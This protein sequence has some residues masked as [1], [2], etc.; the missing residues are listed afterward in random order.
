MNEQTT[1]GVG[2]GR[3]TFADLLNFY[4]RTSETPIL[5]GRS[6]AEL[7]HLEHPPGRDAVVATGRGWVCGFCDFKWE[8]DQRFSERLHAAEALRQMRNFHGYRDDDYSRKTEITSETMLAIAKLSAD[9]REEDQPEKSMEQA[10]VC[11]A[12]VKSMGFDDPKRMALFDAVSALPRNQRDELEAIMWIG[13]GTKYEYDDAL[14]HAQGFPDD[15]GAVSYI[16]GKP[17]SRYLPRGIAL[18][19]LESIQPGSAE[20]E[21]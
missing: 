1:Y 11:L 5:C 8:I 21:F 9:Y 12:D 3:V 6:T 17:L 13:A 4:Q 10:I 15:Q 7:G 14:E 16:M 2:D 18:I 20:D 19:G